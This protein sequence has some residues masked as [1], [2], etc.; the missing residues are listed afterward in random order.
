MLLERFRDGSMVLIFVVSGEPMLM[1]AGL[2]YS[3]SA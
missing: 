1:Q 2:P 3:F